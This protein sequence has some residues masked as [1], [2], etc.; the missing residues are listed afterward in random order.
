MWAPS[1]HVPFSEDST[2][3]YVGGTP[4]SPYFPIFWEEMQLG[5]GASHAMPGSGLSGV[6]G[7]LSIG[8]RL[9]RPHGSSLNRKSTKEGSRVGAFTGLY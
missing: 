4:L 2:D 8:I 7:H 9:K 3:E 6:S 5:F 1:Q